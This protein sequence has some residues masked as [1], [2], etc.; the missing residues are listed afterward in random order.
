MEYVGGGELYKL[1]KSIKKFSEEEAK[2]IVA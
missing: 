1:L 2:F